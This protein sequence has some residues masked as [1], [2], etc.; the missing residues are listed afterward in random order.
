MLGRLFLLFTVVTLVEMFLLVKL[1]SWMGFFS[2]VALVLVTGALGAWAARRQGLRVLVTL[3]EELASGRMPTGSLVA[4]L[5]V[6]IAGAL[7]MTPGILTD[8]V[9]FALLFP[10]AQRP[11]QAALTA[12]F[13]RWLAE[14]RATVVHQRT[15]VFGRPPAGAG[16]AASPFGERFAERGVRR[17]IVDV[18]V[19]DVD[20]VSHE[21]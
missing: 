16:P 18:D 7:L 13:Q 12:A 3:R 21:A 2:T 15:V 1:A 4:G 5:C 11:I 9:G 19:I 14:G 17:D 20:A 8:V 6:V 10:I